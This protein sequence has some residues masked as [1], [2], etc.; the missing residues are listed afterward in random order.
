MLLWKTAQHVALWHTFDHEALPLKAAQAVL[1]VLALVLSTLVPLYQRESEK[2][3]PR[4]LDKATIAAG[5]FC[6]AWWRASPSGPGWIAE[7]G[8][9]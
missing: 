8:W 3:A 1:D 4:A 9:R 7:S 6:A 2:E 5:R